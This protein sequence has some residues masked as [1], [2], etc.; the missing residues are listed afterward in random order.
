MFFSRVASIEFEMIS[1]SSGQFTFNLAAVVRSVWWLVVSPPA[2]DNFA[3]YNL[4]FAQFLPTVDSLSKTLIWN[5]TRSRK[6][7]AGENTEQRRTSNMWVILGQKMTQCVFVLCFLLGL[8]SSSFMCFLVFVHLFN[9]D[10]FFICFHVFSCFWIYFFCRSQF[11]HVLSVF[12]CLSCVLCM[13][14]NFNY[15]LRHVFLCLFLL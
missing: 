11:M 2:A 15:R 13:T 3:R 1:Y 5:K 10:M 9:C 12:L 8:S 14:N 6:T 7:F 4:F